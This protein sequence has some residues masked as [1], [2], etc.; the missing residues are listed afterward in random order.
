[1][2]KLLDKF[3]ETMP[4]LQASHIEKELH[5][6]RDRREI[7]SVKEFRDEFQRRLR[8]LLDSNTPLFSDGRQLV[9]EEKRSSELVELIFSRL[10]DDISALFNDADTVAELARI[11]GIL[12]EDEILSRLRRAVAEA[13]RELDRI[14]LLFGNV[15]GLQDAIIERFRTSSS[16]LSHSDPIA[17]MVYV[18]PKENISFSAKSDMPIEVNLG[19]LVLPIDTES[20]LTFS[21]IKDQQSADT[22]DEAD[23]FAFPRGLEFSTPSDNDSVQVGRLTSIIDKQ[24]NTWW[25]KSITKKVPLSNGAK[26]TFVLSIGHPTEINF[27]EIQ[28]WGNHPIELGDLY[29]IDEFALPHRIEFLG[30]VSTISEPTRVFFKAVYATKII[31]SFTQRNPST[32][33]ALSNGAPTIVY[34]Y[35]FGF[36]NI[37][38]GKLS[39]ARQGCYVSNTLTAPNINTLYLKVKENQTLGADSDNPG[40]IVDP[41]PTIEYWAAFRDLDPEGNITFSTILPILPVATTR[42]RERLSIREGHTATLNFMID[43]QL[44]SEDHDAADLLLYRDGVLVTRP[45]DYNI[46]EGQL[47]EELTEVKRTILSIPDGFNELKEYIADYKPL[48]I[49]SDRAPLMFLDPSGLIRY[50]LDSTINIE[51]PA[52]SRAVRSEA[53]LII[54]MRNCG[55]QIHTSLVDEFVFA[56]G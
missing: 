44:D 43:R 18:D 45:T 46:E 48:H 21:A 14:E 1:M 2:G 53:N 23:R 30:D 11:Q 50:N 47:A 6:A 49:D 12:F 52:G 3:V 37:Y 41:V 10:T 56:V 24:N 16:R 38:A 33:P 34:K 32:V 15:S 7:R 4:R 31:A 35:E 55:N 17:Q 13:T 19:G 9:L 5:Q 8:L 29:Y 40:V 42:V 25:S 22:R 54:I 36:D 28:P 26:L 20:T 39:Y 51:R 27:I